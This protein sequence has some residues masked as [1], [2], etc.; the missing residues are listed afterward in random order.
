[1]GKEVDFLPEDKEQDKH[2]EVTKLRMVE[3]YRPPV[4]FPQ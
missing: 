4:S 1:M 3:S 2:G